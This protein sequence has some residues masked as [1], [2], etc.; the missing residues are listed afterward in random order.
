MNVQQQNLYTLY[1][2]TQQLNICGFSL[3]EGFEKY[4]QI[5]NC[6]SSNFIGKEKGK[7]S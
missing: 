5:S 4:P 7:E 2:Y 3:F 6:S 1:I